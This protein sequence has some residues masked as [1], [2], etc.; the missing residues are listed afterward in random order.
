MNAVLVDIGFGV[1]ALTLTLVSAGFHVAALNAKDTRWSGCP[2]AVI[3]VLYCVL[4]ALIFL[5][6]RDLSI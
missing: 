4:M 6:W 5:A 1:V 2:Q 3:F